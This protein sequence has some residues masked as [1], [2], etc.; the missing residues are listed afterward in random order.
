MP[1]LIITFLIFLIYLIYE[2][3]THNRRINSIPLRIC[4]TGTRGKTGVTRL[5][6]CILRENGN[7]VFAKTTGSQAAIILPDSSD[8]PVKRYG[9]PSIIEQKKLINRA[10]K[11]NADCIVSEIMSIQPEN[12]YVES[13]K[14][15]KPNIVIITNTRKDHTETMGS[16]EEKISSVLSLCITEKAKVFIPENENR[17]IFAQTVKKMGGELIRVSS[18]ASSNIP[19]LKSGVFSENL[20]IVCKVSEYLNVDKDVIIKGI[21]NVKYDIGE[22]R[23]WKYRPPE[24][25]KTIYLVNAFAANDP[26]ST[27]RIILK[28]KEI[29]QTDSDNFTGILNLRADRGDRTLQWI[30]T[31][32]NGRFECLKRIYA[33]GAHSRIVKRKAERIIVPDK[34]SPEYLM[35]TVIS[36]SNDND[37]VFG[38]GN[39][40]G[41]GEVLVKY[42]KSIGEEHGL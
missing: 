8:I 28:T 29:L 26:E 11:E 31:L 4:V 25:G 41:M 12:H 1:V 6:A 35:N 17:E 15:L 20:N 18:G 5:I 16:T 9:I 13:D 19:G 36:D 37:V 32:K 7:K 10:V 24:N 42:W 21:K 40:K 39:M 38:F 27:Y 23:I 30:E 22:F 33:V 2:S 14:I 3:I 34:K